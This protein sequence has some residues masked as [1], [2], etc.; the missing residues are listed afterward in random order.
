MSELNT[1]PLWHPVHH[2]FQVSQMPHDLGGSRLKEQ[3]RLIRDLPGS[4]MQ[5]RGSLRYV[6]TDGHF[7]GDEKCFFSQDRRVHCE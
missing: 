3:E 6:I 1:V 5:K 4:E 2:R 7:D